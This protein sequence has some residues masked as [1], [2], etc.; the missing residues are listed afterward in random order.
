MISPGGSQTAIAS[1]LHTW[2]ARQ[3]M[4]NDAASR[5]IDQLT[6][7]SITS[8]NERGSNEALKAYQ[9]FGTKGADLLSSAREKWSEGKTPRSAF[10][11]TAQL[12]LHAKQN[13]TLAKVPLNLDI[14]E[15]MSCLSHQ[16]HLTGTKTKKKKK[17]KVARMGGSFDR[18]NSRLSRNSTVSKRT[19]TPHRKSGKKSATATAK[20][21]GR[22][23]GNVSR[24]SAMELQAQ[25]SLTVSERLLDQKRNASKSPHKPAPAYM[26][27]SNFLMR[28][29]VRDRAGSLHKKRATPKSLS[30]YAR[31]SSLLRT[32]SVASLSAGEL[33]K[34][35]YW[36]RW[37]MWITKVRRIRAKA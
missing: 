34:R 1:N 15:D 26:L 30:P 14:E 5:Q 32:S 16:S 31:Q 25:Q 35:R 8:H 13:S 21:R 2:A 11:E 18:D 37:V 10:R 33:L 3:N 9:Y 36:R 7:N 4:A 17:K 29:P 27:R 22:R 24:I 23:T 6:R 19:R 28:S 20:R 12:G